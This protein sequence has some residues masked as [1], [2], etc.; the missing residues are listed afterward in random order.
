MVTTVEAPFTFL[1]EKA[2]A[3][4][5]DPV[6]P[7]KMA[8]GLVPKIL[9]PVDMVLLV[10]EA[11]RMVD[12][13]VM[14]PRHV[15]GIV[16]SEAVR[17]D[18]TVR[19]NHALHDGQERIATGVGD[20]PSEHMTTTLQQAEYRH[21]PRSATPSLSLTDSSKIALIDFD[22]TLKRG[23]VFQLLGND[24]P[25]AR[26]EGSCSVAMDAHQ[27]RSCPGCR[28]GNEVLHE[29]GLLVGTEPTFPCV[30]GTILELIDEL[31]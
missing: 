9:D 8:L 18:D 5:W 7:P 19:Q 29:P 30:H 22:L 1:E 23:G 28:S 6:E 14:K 31:S 20:H 25:Q 3:F 10:N 21:F 12:A 2:E 15:K 26:E 27:L 4:L 11:I 13:N 16:A 17:V 24:R